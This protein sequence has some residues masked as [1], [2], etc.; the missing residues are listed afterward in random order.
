MHVVAVIQ[1]RMGSTRLPGKVMMEICGRPVLWHVVQRAK[2]AGLLAQVVIAT[3]TLPQDDVLADLAGEIGV[4][5]YRGPVDDVLYRYYGAAVEYGANAV[6]RITSDCPLLDPAVVD[7]VLS[8]HLAAGAEVDYTSNTM[9][10]TFPRGLDTEVITVPALARAHREA[11][12]DYE[13]EH[14][15]PYIYQHPERFRLQNVEAAGRLRR[16][17]LRLTVD[18]AEDLQLIREIYGGLYRPGEIFGALDVID[19]LE[20]NPALVAINA[21]VRQKELTAK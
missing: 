13:R 12:R 21:H 7:K 5:C 14:V 16:P 11:A 9:E 15:T 10:R 2:A 6:V 20:K 3:T 19:F 17:D 18:T 4:P 1:A 8:T